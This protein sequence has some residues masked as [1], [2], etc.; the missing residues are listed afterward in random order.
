MH[1]QNSNFQIKYFIAGKC[2]TPDEAYRQLDQLRENRHVAVEN[3]R[4]ADLRA[5]AKVAKA[6][7]TMADDDA[8]E[9]E[10]LESEADI[11]ELESF[12]EQSDA[13]LAQARRE[14][15]YIEGLMEEI[16]PECRYVGHM[17]KH[18]AY[19]LAQETEWALELMWRAENFL[20]SN[21]FIPHDHMATMRMHPEWEQ[22]IHPYVKGLLTTLR[23]TTP[24]ALE[25]RGKKPHLRIEDKSQE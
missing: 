18:E 22:T 3:A 20:A 1:W 4:A 15:A 11:A 2:H 9:W 6:K 5:R 14:L 17:D 7:H 12:A 24:E 19:Q 13:A 21:G 10:K 16:L 25:I 23:S 8:P